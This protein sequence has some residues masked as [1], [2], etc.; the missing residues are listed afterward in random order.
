MYIY[1]LYIQ[2]QVQMRMQKYTHIYIYTFRD[3]ESLTTYAC[4]CMSK[5]GV[6]IAPD[7]RYVD[8]DRYANMYMH[9]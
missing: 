9:R 1:I 8:R 5:I 4:I 3:T 6:D 7:S 2:I